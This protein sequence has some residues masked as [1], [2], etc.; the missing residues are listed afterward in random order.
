MGGVYGASGA[1]VVGTPTVS[2][3]EERKQHPGARCCQIPPYSYLVSGSA[4]EKGD[5]GAHDRVLLVFCG[6]VFAGSRVGAGPG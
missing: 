1:C 5:A 3:G 2:M 6:C 4:W